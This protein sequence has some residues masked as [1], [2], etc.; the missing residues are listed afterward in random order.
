M[1]GACGDPSRTDFGLALRRFDA[2]IL[3][4]IV[5]CLLD[6]ELPHLWNLSLREDGAHG[7]DRHAG[8]AVDALLRMNKELILILVKTLDGTNLDAG[9]ILRPD[10]RLSHHIGH[11]DAS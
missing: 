5:D 11:V 6:E 7:T 10:A 3:S 8:V 4:E 2:W 1:G 9:P